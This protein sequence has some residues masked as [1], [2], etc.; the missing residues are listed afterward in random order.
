MQ[1]RRRHRGGGDE[2]RLPKDV[3]RGDGGRTEKGPQGVGRVSGR[4]TTRLRTAVPVSVGRLPCRLGLSSL[5]GQDPW[6]A[7]SSGIGCFCTMIDGPGRERRR[8][9][10]LIEI[11]VVVAI[12]GVLAAV[13]YPVFV[14]AKANAK[15]TPC[16]SNLGQLGKAVVLYSTDNEDGFPIGTTPKSLFKS[17][18]VAGIG[19]GGRVYGYVKGKGVYRCP[20]DDTKSSALGITA[21]TVSY[22]LNLNTAKVKQFSQT[23]YAS[24][25]VLLFEVSGNFA[26]ITRPDEA[27]STLTSSSHQVSAIGDGTQ[28]SLLAGVVPP[29][30][31]GDGILTYHATGH[32]DNYQTRDGGDDYKAVPPRHQK[33]AMYVAMDGHAVWATGSQVSAGGNAKSPNDPQ[34]KTGC[35]GL[36]TV[37]HLWPCAEGGALNGH[38]LTFSLQ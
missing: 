14:A 19:W 37:L 29:T 17:P 10:T 12:L 6:T 9:F 34:T 5:P 15:R 25:S 32:M 28:G 35:S 26:Q 20:S 1:I 4:P 8:A 33:G 11:L 38:K 30:G 31:P 7:Q 36:G 21:D 27:I 18:I 3:E 13:L 2:R 23:A 22:A 16:L 24:R